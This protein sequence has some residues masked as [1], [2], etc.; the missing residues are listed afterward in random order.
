MITATHH[1]Q[2][3]MLIGWDTLCGAVWLVCWECC[4]TMLTFADHTGDSGCVLVLM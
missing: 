4:V 1:N 2:L 3:S